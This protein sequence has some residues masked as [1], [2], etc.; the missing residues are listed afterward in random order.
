MA[1]GQGKSRGASPG[2]FRVLALLGLAALGLGLLF[3]PAGIGPAPAAGGEPAGAGKASTS[4][5]YSVLTSG[6]PVSFRMEEN[7]AR[8]YVLQVPA[9][10]RRLTVAVSDSSGSLTLLTRY[11][12]WPTLTVYD[13][14]ASQTCSH[15]N[16]RAGWWYIVLRSAATGYGASGTLTATCVSAGGGGGQTPPS[17]DAGSTCASARQINYNSR[18]FATLG[19]VGDNDYYRFSFTGG[20]LRAH[21]SGAIDTYGYLYNSSCRLLEE[22]DDGGLETNFSISRSLP[23]GDYYLRVRAFDREVTGS[24]TLYLGGGAQ[25]YAEG[26]GA[27]QG[28]SCLYALPLTLGRGSAQRIDY[29]GENDYFRIQVPRAGRLTVYTTG[30]IDTYGHLLGPQCLEI[31]Y[32][33][34]EGSGVNFRIS[35]QVNP[36]NYYLRVTHFAASGVGRYTVYAVLQ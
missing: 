11:D 27:A 36:G 17:A 15:E 33:D 4:Y 20:T 25:V 12:D 22:N 9:N 10:Q 26:N 30:A 6:Q 24:Y 3:S 23:Q 32:D 34:D 35:R 14:S 29:P 8:Y 7:Q 18:T 19:S 2:S 1:R 13:C 21:T 5:G 31:A 16:P 28:N